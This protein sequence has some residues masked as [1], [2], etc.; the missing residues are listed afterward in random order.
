MVAQHNISEM[1]LVNDKLDTF[2]GS[3]HALIS[4]LGY[5]LR[6]QSCYTAGV[7]S[8]YALRADTHETVVLSYTDT[9][10]RNTSS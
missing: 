1:K 7:L 5:K 10:P 8:S 6:G 3:L 4:S 9:R 2:Y